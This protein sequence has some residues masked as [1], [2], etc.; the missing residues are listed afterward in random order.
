MKSKLKTA[1]NHGD[2]CL[3]VWPSAPTW[4]KSD[5]KTGEWLSPT[6]HLPGQAYLSSTIWGYHRGQ[7]E[8]KKCGLGVRNRRGLAIRNEMKDHEEGHKPPEVQNASLSSIL[9]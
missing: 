6:S 9:E 2:A 3:G 8:R 1:R 7:G 5:K 4:R